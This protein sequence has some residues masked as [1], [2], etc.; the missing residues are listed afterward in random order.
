VPPALY[1]DFAT[2]EALD[3]EYDVER[4]VGDFSAYARHYVDNSKLARHRLKCVLDVP[5]GATL[6]ERLDIFPAASAPAP[7]LV[8]FHGGY[9][10]MLSNKEFSLVALGPVPVGIAVVNVNYSLCPKVT[11]DEIVRQAR[12]AV[13]WTW[14]EGA[15]YGIDR[16]RLYVAGHSAGA[17][18]A[19]MALKADWSGDYGMP[20]DAIRG[21]FCVSGLYDLRPLPY[22][23]VQPSLQLTPDQVFRNSPALDPPR[24]SSAAMIVSWGGEE[25]AEFRRQSQD[26]VSLWQR[27]G[28]TC[29]ALPQPQANHFTALYGLE[30]AASPLCA[31][32]L[33]LMGMDVAARRPSLLR[34]RDF[35]PR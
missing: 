1:R 5:Y 17:H 24:R 30:D 31:A 14:R 23:F 4:Q 13:A 27:A 12:A 16:D 15:R 33:R 26:L 35:G 8:F 28:N 7:V 20:V 2:Q 34:R 6:D 18:L 21:A 25:S 29:E 10:R 22:C 9:W 32:L 3:L 11:I 19:A